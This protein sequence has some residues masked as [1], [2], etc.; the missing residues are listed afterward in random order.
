MK[1]YSQLAIKFIYTLPHSLHHIEERLHAMNTENRNL[2][3]GV[4]ALECGISVL[5]AAEAH[6]LLY[7][8]S[9]ASRDPQPPEED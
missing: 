5:S 7:Y 9:A 1:C 4:T 8:S 2:L 3:G 6:I